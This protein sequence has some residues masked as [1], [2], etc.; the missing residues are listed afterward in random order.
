MAVVYEDIEVLRESVNG[1]YWNSSEVSTICVGG[2]S[3]MNEEGG[4]DRW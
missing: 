1:G 4:V 3:T 2:E